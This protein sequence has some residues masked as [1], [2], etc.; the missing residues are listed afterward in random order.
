MIIFII[1][2]NYKYIDSSKK[3]IIYQYSELEILF[4]YKK[5]KIEKLE[6]C[7]FCYNI[8][9]NYINIKYLKFSIDMKIY[10]PLNYTFALSNDIKY[11]DLSCFKCISF[12]RNLFFGDVNIKYLNL[13]FINQK[14]YED[15]WN[16][17]NCKYINLEN[18][19]FSDNDY[20][21][22]NNLKSLNIMKCKYYYKNNIT[23][24]PML[25][26]LVLK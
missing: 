18:T 16:C 1:N 13:Q 25:K 3:L 6:I 17:K 15:F 11:I 12:C 10:E 4:I 26:L 14:S 23:Y 21:I 20:I 19:I 2:M 22:N 5:Y 9:L 7:D 8:F 24:I